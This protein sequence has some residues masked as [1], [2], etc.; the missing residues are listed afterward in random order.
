MV[1]VTNKQVHPKTV[2]PQSPKAAANPRPKPAAGNGAVPK[3]SRV[4]KLEVVEPPPEPAIPIPGKFTLDKFKSKRASTT[5]NVETLVTALPHY[6]IADAK[7]FVRLHPNEDDYWSCELC[8]VNVPIKGTKKDVPHM[9]DEDIALQYLS[10]G[11]I[12]RF[13]LVLATKP[14]D[15]FF[16][17]HVPSHNLENSWNESSHSA[18]E[19]AKTLWTQVASR[20]AEGVDAYKADYARDPDAFPEPK[21]PTRSLEEL[22]AITFPPDLRIDHADHP[23]LLRLV[24]AKQ[25]MACGWEVREDRCRRFRV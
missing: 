9:I 13:R 17:C 16:L 2:S 19:K 18:C 24:G 23:A 22:I 8:F 25:S 4:P 1:D 5:G 10:N 14:Y 11:R 15:V 21:W 20:R 3:K 6:R 12:Q 7:D